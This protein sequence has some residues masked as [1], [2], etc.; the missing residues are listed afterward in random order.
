MIN[1]PERYPTCDSVSHWSSLQKSGMTS[2]CW[3]C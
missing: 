2:L 1:K 3:K